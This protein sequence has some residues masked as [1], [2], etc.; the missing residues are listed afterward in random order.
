ME[1]YTKLALLVVLAALTGG[2][3]FAP[4]RYQIARTDPFLVRLDTRTGD[5]KAYIVGLERNRSSVDR[6]EVRFYEI[7]DSRYDR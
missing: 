4:G 5:M 7:A 2:V 3:W 6:Q 1:R